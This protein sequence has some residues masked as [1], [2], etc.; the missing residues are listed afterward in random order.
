MMKKQEQ[1][2]EEL[3]LLD[4]NKKK[5]DEASAALFPS[6]AEQ[7]SLQMFASKNNPPTSTTYPL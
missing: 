6:N 7:G 5:E 4:P 2:L 3:D 1:K